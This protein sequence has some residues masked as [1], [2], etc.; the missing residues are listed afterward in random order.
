M[1]GL[2]PR[3]DLIDKKSTVLAQALEP[4]LNGELPKNHLE[5]R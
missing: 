2:Y 3:P 4:Y 5:G 1:N